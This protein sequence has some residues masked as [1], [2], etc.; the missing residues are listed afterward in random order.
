MREIAWFRQYPPYHAVRESAWIRPHSR[1]T[2]QSGTNFRKGIQPSSPQK[3]RIA[4][5]TRLVSISDRQ[6]RSHGMVE[7][8][9]LSVGRA[10]RGLSE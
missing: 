10:P 7:F 2:V 3:P 9:R 6:D 8:R 1:R 4:E 5:R